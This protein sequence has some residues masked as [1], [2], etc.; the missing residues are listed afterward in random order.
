MMRWFR[1]MSDVRRWVAVVIAAVAGVLLL[2][3]GI[4]GPTGTYEL[5]R[6]QLPLFI[7]NQQIL[8][9][10]DTVALILIVISLAGG[11][12]VLAG[13][14]LIY[15][16]HVSTG[17]LLIGLGAGVGIPWLIML[18]IGLI[19]TGQV[20]AVI[21]QHSSIGWIG[22]IMAFAARIIAK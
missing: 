1:L 9:V 17:K 11:V 15:K 8:Q 20:A 12:S 14:F 6:E 5:M 10:V 4:R 21:A 7:Q 19:T 22:V 18:A 2:V 13:A 3:S 16:D